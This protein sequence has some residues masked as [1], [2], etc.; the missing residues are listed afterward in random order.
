MFCS[1]LR[2]WREGSAQWRS[3]GL[4][5]VF[6][7]CPAVRTRPERPER[8]FFGLL[9]DRD[10]AG[11]IARFI[12]RFIRNRRLEG[13]RIKAECLHVSLHHVGG[14]RRLRGNTLFA[15][16]QAGNAVAVRP[17]EMT[18]RFMRTY[19]APR[20]AE[21]RARTPLVLL[22]AADP[23]ASPHKS[24]G[25]AMRQ[26]GLKP[27]SHFAPHMTL[28]YGTQAI[29][30]QAIEPIRTEVDQF[31]LIHSELGHAR[32][33]IVD[34]W[35]LRDRMS[36]NGTDRRPAGWRAMDDISAVRD[37]PA[38]R[39]F[40]LDIDGA[41]AVAQYRLDGDTILFTHTEVPARLQGRGIGSRLVRGA[42]DAARARGL[43]V[44]PLCSFVA[45][46][47]R[48]HPEVKDLVDPAARRRTS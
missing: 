42:L 4:Q 28:L 22:G 16:R 23:L 36:G 33:N 3:T 7:F 25:A 26:N 8:L 39:R 14:F 44:V 43:R 48:R 30:L 12:N 15:A 11:R 40:E 46:Y 2:S 41:L 1:I 20:L 35:P 34:R 21:G 17:F 19:D 18:F 27:S 9:P 24:L 47:I 13:T 29:P 45:D 37:N 32:Y 5:G 6:E 10:T 38:A 31:A